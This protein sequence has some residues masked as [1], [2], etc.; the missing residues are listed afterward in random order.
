M[1]VGFAHP[2]PG[3]VA[4]PGSTSASPSAD[5][6][7]ILS[8]LDPGVRLPGAQGDGHR[9]VECPLSPRARRPV[10]GRSRLVPRCIKRRI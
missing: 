10:L 8:P 7:A 3:E 2:L 6:I 4:E 1:A 9:A 5:G